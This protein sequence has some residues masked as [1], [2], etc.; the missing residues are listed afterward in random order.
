MA[1]SAGAVLAEVTVTFSF[2]LSRKEMD[3]CKKGAEARPPVTDVTE[4]IHSHTTTPQSCVMDRDRGE[5]GALAMITS[6]RLWGRGDGVGDGVALSPR[7][8]SHQ[9]SAWKRTIHSLITCHPLHTKLALDLYLLVF[10]LV[11]FW[12]DQWPQRQTATKIKAE[13]RNG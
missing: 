12:H 5:G 11:F 3:F 2:V 4:I 7:Q 1:D 9:P 10:L 8:L 6:T 13:R